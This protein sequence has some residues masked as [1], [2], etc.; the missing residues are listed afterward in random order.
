EE[1][2]Q[3]ESANAAWTSV[4]GNRWSSNL[5]LQFSRDDQDSRANT[6]AVNVVV[7]E[8]IS[9]TGRSSILPRQTDEKRLDITE[10]ASYQGR[11]HSLKFGGDILVTRTQNYF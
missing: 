9:G 6:N 3:T 2:V 4:L 5:R 11:T 8:W 7:N 1:R 10:T